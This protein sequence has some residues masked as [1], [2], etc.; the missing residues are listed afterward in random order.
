M[1]T[2]YILN[3]QEVKLQKILPE[4]KAV[5]MEKAKSEQVRLFALLAEMILIL[6]HVKKLRKKLI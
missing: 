2:Q 1:I 3:N 5:M 4:I 6:A